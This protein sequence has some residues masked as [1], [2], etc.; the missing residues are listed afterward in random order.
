MQQLLVNSKKKAGGNSTKENKTDILSAAEI[1]ANKMPGF[2]MDQDK[3]TVN[4][5]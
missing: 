1:F 5:Y 4:G 2:F 3:R